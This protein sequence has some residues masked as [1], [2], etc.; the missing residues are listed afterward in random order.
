MLRALLDP[1][2]AP[3]QALPREGRDL[4]ITAGIGLVFAFG[5]V[6]GLPHWLSDTLC[7][8]GRVF[9]AARPVI[10]NGI[11]EIVTRPD[12]DE[13]ALFL[14]LETVAVYAAGKTSAYGRLRIVGEGS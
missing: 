11:E 6:S 2:T 10:L 9:A 1:H 4:F 7:R 13:R 14:T 5:S 8:P 3:L 12:P